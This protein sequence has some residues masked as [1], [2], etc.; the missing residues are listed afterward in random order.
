M[1][2]IGSWLV[3]SC[4]V[5]TI[6]YITISSPIIYAITNQ[7]ATTIKLP[8]TYNSQGSTVFGQIIHGIF[9]GLII[10]FVLHYIYNLFTKPTDPTLADLRKRN[11]GVVPID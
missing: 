11:G 8:A 7:I 1:N 10:Y 5:L 6:L 9:F 2:K 3:W 4:V